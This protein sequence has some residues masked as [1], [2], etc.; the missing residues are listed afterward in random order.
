M[1]QA[2][3]GYG[4]IVVMMAMIL[5]KKASAAFCFAILPVLGAILCGFGYKEILGFINK[6]E[7]TMW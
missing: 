5:K 6:G 2:L 4:V 3:I 1:V 7:G